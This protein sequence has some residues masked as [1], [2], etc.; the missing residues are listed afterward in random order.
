MGR[1]LLA[2]GVDIYFTKLVN[3][4]PDGNYAVMLKKIQALLGKIESEI[5]KAS[6]KNLEVKISALQKD[7]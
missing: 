4:F 3:T 1:R 6:L 5:L 2:Y 7:K